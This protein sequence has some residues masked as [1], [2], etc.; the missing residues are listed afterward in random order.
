MHTRAMRVLRGSIAA[1]FATFTAAFSHQFAGGI[2]PSLFGM[3][4][5]LVISIAICTLLAGR[6]ISLARL[7][8]AIMASQAMYHA[9]FSSM[10]APTGIAEHNMAAMT[11][12]FSSVAQSA[13][14]AMSLSH[15]VA[16]VVTIVAF[17]YAEV[18]FWGL[19]D[20]ARM[21]VSRLFAT[22]TLGS[23]PVL[24]FRVVPRSTPAVDLVPRF[25][26]I[27]RYRGPPATL[28]AA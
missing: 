14:S 23:T 9:L 16:A 11:F 5:S 13:D 24:E 20:T 21:F 1:F 2:S 28:A 3:G 26:S 25:L 12:D 15:V 22:L 19:F 8:I 6:T 4:V 27:T 7:S 18:A 17:R 10:L